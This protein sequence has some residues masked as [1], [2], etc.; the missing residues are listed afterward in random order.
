MH[1]PGED[2]T[3]GD[4]EE[5]HRSPHCTR[6]CT[7]DR[8]KTGNIQKLYHEQFPL[9]QYNVVNTIVDCNSRSFSVIGIE[10]LVYD[11]AIKQI[12]T[13]QN[14]KADKKADH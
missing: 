12:A 11:F 4:P 9:R 2:G 3:K 5:H 7:E 1:S 10:D 6:Q 13:N 14:N 8:A